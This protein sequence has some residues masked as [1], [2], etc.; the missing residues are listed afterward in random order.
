MKIALAAL[1]LAILSGCATTST[2]V[3]KIELPLP[4]GA[5]TPC[6]DLD[7]LADGSPEAKTRWIAKNAPLYREC[8]A[9]VDAWIDYE[10]AA[11]K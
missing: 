4:V 2:P 7:L 9:K 10:E 1:M 5:M 6:P 8:A 3:P 11:R